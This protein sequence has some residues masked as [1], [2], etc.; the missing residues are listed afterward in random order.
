MGFKCLG[1]LEVHFYVELQQEQQ[2][3]VLQNCG[4]SVE[5]TDAVGLH[6]QALAQRS[7]RLAQRV[8]R[9]AA[10][11]VGQRQPRGG[12]VGRE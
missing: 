4:S 5:L 10:Q 6:A 7:V 9:D 8:Q 11:R 2:A 1:S 12:E 3:L